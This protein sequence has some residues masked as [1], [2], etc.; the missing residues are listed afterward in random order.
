MEFGLN[1][2]EKEVKR[3]KLLLEENDCSG[4]FKYKDETYYALIGTY[5]S[6]K[7]TMY[8]KF[9]EATD[10]KQ[11]AINYIMDE[12]L[13]SSYYLTRFAIRHSW[14]KKQEFVMVYADKELPKD[15]FKNVD[16]FEFFEEY[17]RDLNNR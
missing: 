8:D 3:L 12:G 5:E 15:L 7:T 6:L 4:H 9:V 10:I 14:M 16:E 11:A 1:L 13:G 17:R 2:P